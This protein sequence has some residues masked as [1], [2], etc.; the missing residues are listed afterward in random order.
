MMQ[1][2]YPEAQEISH[3]FIML[4]DVSLALVPK[5]NPMGPKLNVHSHLKKNGI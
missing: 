2:P 5:L 3:L 1:N 4:L